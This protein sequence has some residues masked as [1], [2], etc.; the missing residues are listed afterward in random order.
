MKQSDAK[1][2]V[3]RKYFGYEQF[4]EG[5]ELLVNAI[6]SGRDVM[7]IMPTG[8]G[9]S[10]CYQVPALM[11]PGITL[12]ISPLISLMK[13]QVQ[14]LNQ[15][16]IHAAY[17]NSSLTERQISYALQLA[18]GG[19]YKI[20]YV[21]PER[22]ES[23]NFLRFATSSEISLLA[24]DE[25]HCISHWGQDFRPSYR[26]ITG[27]IDALFRRPTVAAFTATATEEVKADII[28]MLELQ[29]P[30]TL[31]T[32]FDRKNLFFAVKKPADKKRFLLGYVKRHREESGVIYCST[33]KNVDM[34]YEMLQDAGIAVTKYHAGLSDEERRK[35][36]DD[37]IYDEKPVIVATNAFGM[38]IDKSNVR[39][40][41]HY[42]MPQSVENYYQEA[43]RAGR[44]GERAEC[45]LLYSPQDIMTAR[46]LLEHKEISPE[47]IQ[48]DPAEVARLD[49]LRL[50]SMIHYCNTSGCLRAY[51]LRYFG[52]KADFD[53]GNCEN[54]IREAES[55]DLT[56][57]AQNV[58]AG[59]RQL[60]GRFG[61]NLLEGV[62]RGRDTAKIRQYNM[63]GLPCYGSLR[64]MGAA[65]VKNLIEQLVIEEVLE[66]TSDKY[67]LVRLGKYAKDVES[68]ER[69]FIWKKF[70][71]EAETEA[72]IVEDVPAKGKAPKERKKK[73]NSIDQLSESERELFEKLRR[74][75]M[76][77]SRKEGV[78]PYIVFSD[79]TLVDM[80]SRCPLDKEG[81]LRVSG[82]GEN[83]FARFGE[84]FLK[85]IREFANSNFH[86]TK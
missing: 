62:L 40:V 39:Y 48:A 42:N 53:C 73:K 37:F 45:V 75:R 44:D 63:M 59:V 2:E 86:A 18:A 4:R 9:K 11:L 60:R 66:Q 28:A 72:E 74:L 41:V 21:A 10:L 81:M 76:E 36:Q 16:G 55:V 27:F 5:Q 14:S 30:Q 85:E 29:N 70:I 67:A 31:V 65:D 38:G 83:K 35:N 17:I 19:Q 20:I 56:K 54:C 79:K 77:I 82:V 49:N 80:C 43:G 71:G 61:I 12:V 13:D 15:A 64:D 32:G 33:R 52:E 8:A 1:Y 47:E 7:G 22:L 68:G 78:P 3:L 46:F 58:I 24:V 26:K 23:R 69:T 51:L 6:L 25:A 57:E 50:S 34:L 84:Q